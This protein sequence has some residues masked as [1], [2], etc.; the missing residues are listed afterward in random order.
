MKLKLHELECLS[1]GLQWEYRASHLKDEIKCRFYIIIAYYSTAKLVSCIVCYISCITQLSAIK[2][3]QSLHISTLHFLYST[4]VENENKTLQLNKQL[5][6]S[7]Y[8]LTINN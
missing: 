3:L 5:A 7:M 1:I 6:Y 8:L 4:H 2:Q